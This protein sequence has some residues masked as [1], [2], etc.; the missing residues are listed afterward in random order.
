MFLGVEIGLAIAVIVSLLLVTY[1]SAYPHTAVLGRLPGTTVY[2]NVKQYPEA[3]RYAGI[4]M[5]RIDAPIYFANTQNVREKVTKYERQ[6]EEQL[7]ESNGS[8]K[9]IV[10]EMSPVGHIDTSALHILE[11]MNK[12]YKERSI[13]LCLCNP[14]VKVMDKLVLSG[15]ADEIGRQHIFAS[16]HDCVNWCLDEMDNHESSMHDVHFACDSL[17]SNDTTNELLPRDVEIGS[18]PSHNVILAS[19]DIEEELRGE[20]ESKSQQDPKNAKISF[21]TIADGEL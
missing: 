15:L 19:L 4:V 21:A 3:E 14:G 8:L 13:K 18:K 5:V 17:A 16:I 20:M 2:R 6:A 1:E 12:T 11:D 9:Y 10:L 7:R